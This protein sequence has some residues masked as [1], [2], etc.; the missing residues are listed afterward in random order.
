VG[1]HC[2]GNAVGFPDI[3]FRAAGSVVT[4]TGVYIVGRRNPAVDIA[5]FENIHISDYLNHKGRH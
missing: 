4:D 2:I 3:H 1:S 5:L